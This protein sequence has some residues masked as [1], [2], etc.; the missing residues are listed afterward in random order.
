M[1]TATVPTT[2]LDLRFS[3]QRLGRD[4]IIT[5]R[6]LRLFDH[7]YSYL[8]LDLEQLVYL[9]QVSATNRRRFRDRL[10]LLSRAGCIHTFVGELGRPP[11]FALLDKGI[12]IY[13]R[14]KCQEDGSGLDQFKPRRITRPR[15]N[16]AEKI[17][18]HDIGIS[19]LA[20]LQAQS[21]TN[22]SSGFFVR[23]RDIFYTATDSAIRS[24]HKWPV[25]V[26]WNGTQDQFWLEPD[27][28][29]GTG[30]ADRPDGRNVRYFAYEIDCSSET[31]KPHTPLA[32]GQSILRKLL[33]YEITIEQGLLS[34]YLGIDHITPLFVFE[35]EKRRG[36]ALKL[37]KEV[38]TSRRAKD[39]I[40]F[41]LRPRRLCHGHELDF[42]SL[43]WI[44]G[45]GKETRVRL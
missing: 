14:S 13:L 17:R 33:S 42:G 6:D 44:N 38:L 45:L 36:N 31:M 19:D 10:L 26:D 1:T 35:S 27:Y 28:L 21:A 3:S 34:Q 25:S 12:N 29:G 40:L 4:F 16:N 2:Q 7:L 15:H 22:H 43:P 8:R 18:R 41:G 24:S 9:E 39:Q 5:D 32:R 11:I 37:A 20:L 23:H 30:F